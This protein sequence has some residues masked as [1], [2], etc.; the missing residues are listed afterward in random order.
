MIRNFRIYQQCLGTRVFLKFVAC[1]FEQTADF[2]RVVVVTA[3]TGGGVRTIG[4]G[5]VRPAAF[6]LLGGEYGV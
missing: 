3:V 5:G 1:A 4:A 2:W 6:F